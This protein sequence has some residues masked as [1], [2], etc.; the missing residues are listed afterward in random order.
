MIVK[1]Q[2]QKVK[3]SCLYVKNTLHFIFKLLKN[4]NTT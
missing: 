3:F 4:V 2:R 1:L